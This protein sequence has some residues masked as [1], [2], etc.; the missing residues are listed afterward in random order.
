MHK[1]SFL[2]L[3]IVAGAII[4][5]LFSSPKQQPALPD[6]TVKTISI[7]E[8]EQ[9]PSLEVAGFVRGS[10]RA[11]IA[12][13]ASGRILKLFKHEGD[14]V[15]QGETLAILDA[16][17]TDAQLSAT[18]A[19]IDA[20]K[21]TLTDTEKYYDQ[22]VREAKSG[23]ADDSE[24]VKSAKRARDL[25]IQATKNQ[26]ISAQGSLD[27]TQAGKSNFSLIAPFSGSITSIHGRVGENASFGVP[28]ISISTGN[29]LEIE[30][31]V[32]SIDARK[33]TLGNIATFNLPNNTPI[34]GIISDISTGADTQTLKTLVRIHLNNDATQLKLGDF[35]HGQISLS[36]KQATILIPSSA[37]VSRGG[38]SVVFV[39]DGNNT[40]HEQIVKTGKENAGQVEITEGL[41]IDQKLVIE[42]QQYLING[43][44]TKT[45][46]K[47]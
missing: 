28:L 34:S 19:N 11:D 29:D 18:T 23:N 45:Y 20:L 43:V 9:A 44:K 41:S 7:T 33:L 30:T 17:Q 47:E 12:P 38:D 8:T 31:Y 46:G 21:K 6:P 14:V 5:L 39:I 10:N 15:K 37:L 25:Q 24:A 13:T 42:G 22:L 2:A 4:A 40:A 27:I 1:K 3:L 32:S 16:N 26:L 35:L 36:E